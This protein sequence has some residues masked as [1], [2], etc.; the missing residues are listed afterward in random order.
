MLRHSLKRQCR[1]GPLVTTGEEKW[2]SAPSESSAVFHAG[3]RG[4]IGRRSERLSRNLYLPVG[5]RLVNGKKRMHCLARATPAVAQRWIVEHR[6]EC[7]G[8]RDPR[9]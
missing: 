1:L 5:P 2:L 9:A 6:C 4:G 7:Q 8:A 3:G